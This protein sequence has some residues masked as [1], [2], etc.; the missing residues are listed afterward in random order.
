M[1]APS[2][3]IVA[4]LKQQY[5]PEVV[6]R[7]VGVITSNLQGLIDNYYNK[8]RADMFRNEGKFKGH[9]CSSGSQLRQLN[10]SAIRVIRQQYK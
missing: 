9:S 6:E 10:F 1:R 4:R 8:G 2:E 7:V 3:G 5:G